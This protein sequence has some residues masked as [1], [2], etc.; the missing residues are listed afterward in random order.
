MRKTFLLTLACLALAFF[1]ASPA[2]AGTLNFPYAISDYGA[3]CAYAG[4]SAIGGQT[5][6]ITYW[7]SNANGRYLESDHE[8]ISHPDA[9]GAVSNGTDN[10]SYNRIGDLGCMV[11]WNSLNL[12]D[13]A[14]DLGMGD[15]IVNASIWADDGAGSAYTHAAFPLVTDWTGYIF[16]FSGLTTNLAGDLSTPIV[17]GTLAETEITAYDDA[18]DTS[19]VISQA[20]EGTGNTNWGHV[21]WSA[22]PTPV[23]NGA[24][25]NMA[26]AVRG[27]DVYRSTA[28]PATSRPSDFNR[29]NN[30]GA[31]RNDGTAVDDPSS[32]LAAQASGFSAGGSFF[33]NDRDLTLA[34]TGMANEHTHYAI[35]PV[36]TEGLGGTQ[37]PDG[38]RAYFEGTS[39][40]PVGTKGPRLS[41]NPTDA[42][43]VSFSAKL[44]ERG[45]KVT[46]EWRTASESGVIGFNIVRKFKL[47]G[48][49]R[50]KAV[51]VNRSLIGAQGVDGGGSV[52][53]F[54]DT[55]RMP[56]QLKRARGLEIQ[57][58]LEVVNA[59]GTTSVTGH[60]SLTPRLA[61]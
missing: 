20:H 57:Y 14:Q 30:D 21:E 1:V 23:L 43:M 47:N 59:D 56:P 26:N 32:G 2:T 22:A 41:D 50:G 24:V 33:F 17:F 4:H 61:R 48:Q 13:G 49:D 16:V 31:V 60:S 12:Q 51:K 18:L 7:Q 11:S 58:E 53:S 38:V 9:E 10:G 36:L 28:D 42:Q 37:W 29:V 44:S 34:A 6:D 25:N 27:W 15:Q 39:W 3:G 55:L 19:V 8:D 52:Y 40:Y 54:V 45:D 5:T 35:T 46:L